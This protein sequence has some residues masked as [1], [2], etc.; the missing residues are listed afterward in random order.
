M[1][2]FTN[3]FLDDCRKTG[4]N[5]ADLFI[6][7]QFETAEA[8]TSLKH[9]LDQL[10]RNSELAPFSEKYPDSLWLQNFSVLPA[11]ADR[12]KMRVG[13]DFFVR[14][15]EPVMNLLG[16]LS[17]PYCYA[18]ADGA[19]V[20]ALSERIKKNPE[21]RFS[22]TAA[23]VWDVMAPDA[24]DEPGKGFSSILKVRLIHAGIRY[25]IHQSDS[26]N[27]DW[28]FPINQEDMAGTNLSFSLIAIRGLRKMGVVISYEE[29]DAFIHLWNVIGYLLG[30][31]SE[32]LPQ[33]GLEANNLESSIRNRQFKYSEHG[34]GLA[35]SLLN[36]INA[37]SGGKVS[38]NY[39]LGLMR[40]L[41]SDEVSDLIGL[42]PVQNQTFNPSTIKVLTGL[43]QLMNSGKSYRIQ[44]NKLQKQ[45]LTIQNA[46]GLPM[47]LSS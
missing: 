6:Q 8:K 11:W 41:L 10:S 1:N 38:R 45:V 34:S 9:N 36:F 46:M 27:S 20:L 24:F 2:I 17:L 19:R 14:F 26:W 40:Y 29:Q 37:N 13:S 21:Q 33:T 3:S 47:S 22:E 35:A 12:K 18:A 4:D 39:I 44:Q 43:Q 25:Y 28:G 16:L 5:N 32:L 42:E 31:I 15:S 7:Q 23:F 30:L